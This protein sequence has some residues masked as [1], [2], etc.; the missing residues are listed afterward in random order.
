M[1]Y[2]Y[3]GVHRQIFQSFLLLAT[4]RSKKWKFSLFITIA[5]GIS[6]AHKNVVWKHWAKNWNRK[7]FTQATIS[8]HCR[9]IKL[10]SSK[11]SMKKMEGKKW[12]WELSRNMYILAWFRENGSGNSCKK[13]IAHVQWVQFE[14][15]LAIRSK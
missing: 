9:R 8:L 13:R 10:K 5:S 11:G 12:K 3:F 2:S 1:A 6:T 4:G 15:N 14:I 7:T